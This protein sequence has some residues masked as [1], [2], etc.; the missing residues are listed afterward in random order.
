MV[1]MV[2]VMDDVYRGGLDVVELNDEE[3][4]SMCIGL[5]RLSD[6]ETKVT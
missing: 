1:M 6:E 5:M 3:C 2:S 4:V